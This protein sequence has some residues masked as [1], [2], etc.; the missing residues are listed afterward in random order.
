[1]SIFLL[2]CSLLHHISHTL[3]FST[4]HIFCPKDEKIYYVPSEKR[5]ERKTGGIWYENN[6]KA[7]RCSFSSKKENDEKFYFISFFLWRKV[8]KG[9]IEKR[10]WAKK[11]KKSYQNIFYDESLIFL[12]FSHFWVVYC[13]YYRLEWSFVLVL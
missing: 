9:L 11:K 7:E 10:L 8:E 1:M 6:R 12:I 3:A 2:F 4:I 5:E 13:Y